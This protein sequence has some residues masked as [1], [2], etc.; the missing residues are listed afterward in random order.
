VQQRATVAIPGSNGWLRVHI[1]DITMGATLLDVVTA[2]GRTL[3][4][5]Q[6]VSERDVVEFA[7]AGERCALVVDRLVNRLVGEDHAE[8]RV[9]PAANLK[10]DRIAQLVRA[11]RES[12]DTFVRDG[13]DWPGTAAAQLLVAK[14]SSPAGRAATLDEFIDTLGSRSS[15]TGEPYQVRRQDGTTVTMQQWLRA[16]LSEIEA[17]ERAAVSR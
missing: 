12:K 16:A 9:A 14:V 11:V 4:L 15:T 2:D 5:Q 7:L 3:V 13:K 10:P 1:D 6:T 8:L 17:R